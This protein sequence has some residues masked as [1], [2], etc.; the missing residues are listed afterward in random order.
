MV[1]SNVTRCALGKGRSASLALSAV[2]RR[3]SA[4]L[5]AFGLYMVTPFCPTRLNCADDPTRDRTLRPP[6]P[7]FGWHHLSYSEVWRIACITP[8]RRWVSNW[9]RLLLF[10]VGPRLTQF[11]GLS[12]RRTSLCTTSRQL[13]SILSASWHCLLVWLPSPSRHFRVFPLA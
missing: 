11:I 3:I 7:G 2:L 10:L 12:W 1:D 5:V 13:P 6:V 8:T 4:V 9:I